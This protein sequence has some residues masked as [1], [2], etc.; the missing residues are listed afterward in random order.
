MQPRFLALLGLL[1]WFAPQLHAHDPYEISSV[2]YVYADRIDV[3]VD[4]EQRTAFKLAGIAPPSGETDKQATTAQLQQFAANF[5]T[6]TAGNHV[7]ELRQA[8][9]ES[10]HDDHL[11]LHLEFSPS[12]H[13]PLQ[14]TTH[15]LERA[16][17]L[18]YGT[19]LTVLDMES[20][21]V[22][23]QTTLFASTPSAV[24]PP[25]ANESES[26]ESQ[27]EITQETSVVPEAFTTAPPAP[28]IE[29][30]ATPVATP[31]RTTR[32]SFLIG[33]GV[34]ALVFVI[35]AAWRNRT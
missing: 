14:F 29:E 27:S 16:G 18:P 24:F 22:L 32:L 5:F 34:I 19:T 20:Q 4:L 21:K 35:L 23:G 10:G 11:Q 1:F 8:R 33:I 13:R 15:G 25:P 7:L 31:A 30:T 26:A 3:V 12:S 17:D 9:V 2:A 6:C 28:P